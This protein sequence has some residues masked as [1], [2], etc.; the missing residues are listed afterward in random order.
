MGGFTN[1][2]MAA[3]LSRRI[4]VEQGRYTMRLGWRTP[5]VDNLK[6]AEL[7][8]TRIENARK[9]RKKTFIVTVFWWL[10]YAVV[11]L[12]GGKRGTCLGPPF[13]GAPP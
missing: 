9:V 10:L 3:R 12:R 4:A 11:C 6:L 8:Y 13:L 2:K 7:A 1:K 5:R